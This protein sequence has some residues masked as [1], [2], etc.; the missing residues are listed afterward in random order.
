MA[1]V[2]IHKEAW[3]FL[4]PLLVQDAVKDNML[5]YNYTSIY[6]IGLSI[7]FSPALVEEVKFQIK[8]SILRIGLWLW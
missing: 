2:A 3:A 1:C 8:V 4:D 5:I 7:K 6:S